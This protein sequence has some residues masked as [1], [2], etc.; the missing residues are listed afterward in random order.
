MSQEQEKGK[1]GG[2]HGAEHAAGTGQADSRSAEAQK[3]SVNRE[4][5]VDG[6][7]RHP[8]AFVPDVAQ[9]PEDESLYRG[10]D[11]GKGKKQWKLPA[12]GWFVFAGLI[13]GGAI[14]AL[15][16]V[17]DEAPE[18]EEK[19]TVLEVELVDPQQKAE[20]EK[21]RDT[22]EE[23]NSC[24]RGYLKEDTIKGK[25]AYVRH[26]KRVRPLMVQYYESHQMEAKQFQQ[27]ESYRAVKI[28]GSS[29]VFGRVVMADGSRQELLLEQLENGSFK[30]DWESDVCYLPMPWDDYISKRPTEPLVMRVHARPDNFYAYG[31]DEDRYDCFQL[32][33]QG[34]DDYLFGYTIKGSEASIAL[35]GFFMRTR[36]L[37]GDKA[38]PVTLLLRFPEEGRSKKCVHIDR[39]MAPRWIF[40]HGN[41]ARVAK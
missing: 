11:D 5:G 32:T 27:F 25:L 1:H 3:S 23:L 31:F 2:V 33:A 34:S 21:V 24:A 4:L 30:V 37:A 41:E 38:E 13:L 18:P 28:D 16:V 10:R 17:L 29:F 39:M 8:G 14:I 36:K 22:L 20:V 9:L 26:P 40:V 35:R 15:E 6:N 7:E 12:L 19:P